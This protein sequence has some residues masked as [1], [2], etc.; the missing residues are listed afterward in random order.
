MAE[1]SKPTPKPKPKVVGPFEAV[2]PPEMGA[3]EI[4]ARQ[5][6]SAPV[7]STVPSAEVQRKLEEE[8]RQA[9]E[10]KAM[11]RAYN[12]SLTNPDY[13]KGGMVGSASKRADGCAQRGKTRGKYL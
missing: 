1:K 3:D 9:Q 4:A 10:R 12:R 5:P 7:E 11:E 2:T 6:R 13:A 8:K